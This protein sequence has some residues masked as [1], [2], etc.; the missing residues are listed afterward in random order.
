MA[1]TKTEQ[2]LDLKSAPVF[3]PLEI[4]PVYAN[5]ASFFIGQFD[6]RFVF[7]EIVTDSISGVPR[8]ELRAN[9]VTTPA[10]AKAFLEA[11]KTTVEQFEKIHGEIKWPEPANPAK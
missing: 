7:N 3:N 11:L 5:I 8:V 1:E 10:H 4:A 9:V 2:T 6:I